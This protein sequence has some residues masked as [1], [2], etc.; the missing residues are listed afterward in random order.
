MATSI[1]EKWFLI[2]GDNSAVHFPEFWFEHPKNFTGRKLVTL[3]HKVSK[4]FDLPALHYEKCLACQ[5]ILDRRGGH[6][7]KVVKI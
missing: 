1:V 4:R 7:P 2:Q 6:I 3:C 5:S